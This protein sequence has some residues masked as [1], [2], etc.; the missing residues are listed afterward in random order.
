MI[1]RLAIFQKAVCHVSLMLLL[2]FLYKSCVIYQVIFF[3]TVQ[4]GAIEAFE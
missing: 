1:T 3:G 4:M 2:V